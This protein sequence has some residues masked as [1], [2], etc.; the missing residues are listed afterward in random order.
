M[1]TERSSFSCLLCPFDIPLLWGIFF[2]SRSITTSWY[3]KML[4]AHLAYLSYTSPR[5]S[6]FSKQLL[7]VLL[8]NGTTNK[9]LGSRYASCSWGIIFS[10]SWQSKEITWMCT[11]LHLCVYVFC[12]CN[13]FYITSCIYIKLTMSL[14]N[15]TLIYCYIDYCSLFALFSC[16]LPF[17]HWK[18]GLSVI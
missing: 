3:Y 6:H 11:Y 15:P 17:L 2:F 14:M 1:A 7:F 10:N 9:D 18:V 16:N 8:E 4:Q 13:G 12:I 5:I